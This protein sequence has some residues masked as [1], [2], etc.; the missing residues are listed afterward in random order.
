MEA[1]LFCCLVAR[2]LSQ[3][4]AGASSPSEDETTENPNDQENN[5]NEDVNDGTDVGDEGGSSDQDDEEIEANLWIT[6]YT[7][8][9]IAQY[10]TGSG[11]ATTASTSTNENV[12]HIQ[13]QT[14]S[15]SSVEWGNTGTAKNSSASVNNGA[16]T[17]GGSYFSY[18]FYNLFKYK[19]RAKITGINGYEICGISTSSS[20]INTS[21][22]STYSYVYFYGASSSSSVQTSTSAPSSSSVGSQIS[23]CTIYIKLRKAYILGYRVNDIAS[24]GYD[25]KY[26]L[27]AGIAYSGTTVDDD[28]H[29]TGIGGYNFVGWYEGTREKTDG[30]YTYAKGS[31][32]NLSANGSRI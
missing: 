12:F 25:K 27:L 5:E 28:V 4:L 31:S 30:N 26:D 18:N 1:E 7:F 22:T 13:W 16:G 9:V 11:D 6:D 8:T 23:S 21:Y 10:K 24:N 3:R 15:G 29:T 32:I 17:V 19:R 2:L 20:F 14:E